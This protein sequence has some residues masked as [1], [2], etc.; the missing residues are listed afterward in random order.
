MKCANCGG[1]Y[2]DILMP[3]SCRCAPWLRGLAAREAAQLPRPR[4]MPLW[5]FTLAVAAL[6]LATYA[7]WL[8]GMH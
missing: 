6:A 2:D 5:A 7:C 4:T 1:Y 3:A 8:A